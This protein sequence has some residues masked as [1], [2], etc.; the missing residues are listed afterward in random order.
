[1]NVSRRASPAS[2]SSC[3]WAP[4][5]VWPSITSC[6]AR[7]RAPYTSPTTVCWWDKDLRLH[8]SGICARCTRRDL[9]S[10]LAS[11]RAAHNTGLRESNSRVAPRHT[12]RRGI[13]H[14]AIRGKQQRVTMLLVRV[15]RG[16]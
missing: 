2:E 4:E 9:K 8:P 16:T 6:A 14:E 12:G 11:A 15:R 13:G 1:M 7:T 5:T 3:P 10:A